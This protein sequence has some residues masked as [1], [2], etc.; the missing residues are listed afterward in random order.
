MY[1]LNPLPFFLQ[2]LTNVE[3]LVSK[4]KHNRKVQLTETEKC[5]TGEK[6]SQEH[7]HHFLFTSRG[8]FAKNSSWQAKQSI[9]HT[10]V[11]F[12]G[13]CV[14][15]CEDFA[16]NFGDKELNVA[17]QR[18]ITQFLSTK[19]FLTKRTQVPSPTHPTFFSFLD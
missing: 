15:I 6:K 12:Y 9:P 19:Q 4:Q 13:D 5:E 2:Y 17:L 7:A 3:N 10:T 18:T 14:K 16:S 1:H 11:T 8:I